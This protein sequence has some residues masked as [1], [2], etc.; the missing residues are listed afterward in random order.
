MSKG[1]VRVSVIGAGASG[2][3][4]AISSAMAG[5]DVTVFEHR[6]SPLKKLLV[7]GNGKCNFTNKSI[8]RSCYHSSTDEGFIDELLSGFNTDDCIA[9][10]EGMGIR[11]RE[12]RGCFYPYPDTAE[13][14]RSAM[15]MQ[16]KSLGINIITD[17]G[18]MDVRECDD[19][20]FSVNCK[21][22]T[23]VSDSLIIA[24]GSCVSPNTGSDGSGYGLL[25]QFGADLTDIS[26]ALTP[27]V[28]LEDLTSIKGIRC[29]AAL[30]LLDAKGS[31]VEVSSGE[32]Q[33]FDGGLSGI[34][35]MD[36]S[37]AACRMLKSGDRA[38]VEADLYPVTDDEGFMDEIKSRMRLF[39]DRD[40]AG[41]LIG[42]FP[43]KLINYLVHPVDT[44]RED[45]LDLLL[46]RVKHLRFELKE[47]MTEDFS[48]AQTVSGGVPLCD[49]DPHCMLKDHRGIYVTGELLDADGICGGYNLHFAFATGCIAGKSAAG[50]PV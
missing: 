50:S 39:P 23:Y 1:S 24:C 12:R 26:P 22:Q 33:P 31:V 41:C 46:K 20:T 7:T 9:F 19:G 28:T 21:G 8:D 13:S 32:L 10:L 5:A 48:R 35:A 40:L 43:K 25:R 49:I 3:A 2:M 38:F 44:R 29:D 36:I 14:V 16:A 15:L 18:D 37:S 6:E 27:L 45:Y 17:C 42:L 11:A 34:C 4:G 47:E 30:K